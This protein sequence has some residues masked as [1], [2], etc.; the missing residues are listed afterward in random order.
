MAEH[1]AVRMADRTGNGVAGLSWPAM[2]SLREENVRLR[3][4]LAAAQ[5]S[6]QRYEMMLREGDHRIK[7]S[8]QIVSGL[9]SMQ[10][11]RV[12]SLDA[13]NALKAAA[14]RIQSVAHI[15]DALQAG[16]GQDAVDIGRIVETMCWSLQAMAGDP[17][18]VDVRVEVKAIDCPVALAQP[19]TLALN[20]L[21]VNALR[22]AFPDHRPGIVHVGMDKIGAHLQAVVSDNG[23]GLPP[24]YAE[25]KGYGLTLVRAMV[26]QIGGTLRIENADGA[27]FTIMAPI[28]EDE[29]VRN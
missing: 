1:G 15:H 25:G 21:V 11:R 9:V 2:R 6:A 27:R 7:N 23:V 19:V 29:A 26:T 12:E 18:S 13:R 28:P 4:M 3:S 22:H 8:L 16:L 14:A 20:E 24:G 10:A 5:T 17:R